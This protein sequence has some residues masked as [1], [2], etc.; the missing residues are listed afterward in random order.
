MG[1]LFFFDEVIIM[2]DKNSNKQKFQV[3][4]IDNHGIPE[5]RIGPEGAAYDGSIAMFHDLEQFERFVN[6][7]NDLHTRFSSLN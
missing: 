1:S 5:I 4:V 6:A 2:S 3:E 7:I